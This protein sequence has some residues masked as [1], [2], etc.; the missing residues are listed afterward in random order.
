LEYYIKKK[1]LPVF[2]E[3]IASIIKKILFWIF[4]DNKKVEPKQETTKLIKIEG[5]TDPQKEIDNPKSL[6][7]CNFC[8]RCHECQKEFEKE[9]KK[10]DDLKKLESNAAALNYLAFFILFMIIFVCNLSIWVRIGTYKN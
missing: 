10:K 5:V 7:K 8:E 9:K 6:T 4:E 3:K 1:Q 2:A